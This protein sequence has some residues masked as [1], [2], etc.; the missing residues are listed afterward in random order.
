MKVINANAVSSPYTIG[1]PAMTA[2]LGAMHALQRKLVDQFPKLV[3]KGLGVVSHD[4]DLQVSDLEFHSKLKLVRRPA[5][6]Q[7]EVGKGRNSKSEK[8]PSTIP[9]GRCHLTVSLVIEY[10]NIKQKDLETLVLEINKQLHSGLRVAG[11]DI[12][13]FESIKTE[14]VD[15]NNFK[16][17][18]RFLMPGYVL[19]ERK[20]LM[21]EAMAEGQDA[22]DAMLD[23]LALWHYSEQEDEDKE[24]DQKKQQVVWK[25]RRKSETGW[26]VPIATG[27][28]A[29]TDEEPTENQRCASKPHRFAESIVTLGEFVMA[30]RI[31]KFE[32]LLWRYQFD[33][34]NSLYLCTQN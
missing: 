4:F 29:L 28:Q 27:F 23:Y 30:Y 31:E 5:A 1:F 3:F 6:K 16:A 25:S 33:E 11:G 9:E 8:T 34:A 20:D 17:F 7:S 18:S 15:E 12:I 19:K 32:D 2:W 10:D 22:M 24:T 21:L 26:I 14:K 13:D